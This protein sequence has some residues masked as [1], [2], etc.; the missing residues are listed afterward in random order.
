MDQ[1]ALPPPGH[2]R[3]ELDTAW[4]TPRNATERQLVALWEELLGIVSVG[5]QD[6]FFALGGHSLLMLRLLA[7]LEQTFQQ[8]I[9]CRAF[10]VAPTIAHL[11]TLLAPS[12]TPSANQLPFGGEQGVQKRLEQTV[13][14][15]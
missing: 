7:Q 8:A 5:V 13:T 6:D 15:E 10:I 3:P 12:P 11:A 14:E 9:R 2:E 1:Q 4:L